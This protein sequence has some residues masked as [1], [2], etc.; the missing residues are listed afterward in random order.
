MN[1]RHA[2]LYLY[3]DTPVHAGGSTS[4]GEVDLPIQRESNGLPVIWGQSL[5]GALRAAASDP[6]SHWTKADVAAVFGD[7][8]EDRPGEDL[9]PGGLSV[10]DAR[11]VA[12]PVPTTS[13][14]FAWA[15]C[16]LITSRL[17]R[18]ATLT[19]APIPTVG[20]PGRDPDRAT[21][22]VTA[23]GQW[24]DR[25]GVG[26]HVLRASNEGIGREDVEGFAGYLAD[27]AIPKLPASLRDKMRA[28]VVLVSDDVLVDGTHSFAE[29]VHRVRLERLERTEDGPLVDNKSVDN[30]FVSEY[31]PAETLL[32]SH[33]YAFDDPAHL[34][35]LARLVDGQ[36]IRVGGDVSAGKGVVWCSI[37]P[38]LI[39]EGA[40]DA[41]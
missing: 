24:V 39:A 29:V 32:V 17:E 28:D 23:G 40:T 16:P 30:L 3:T 18:L 41:N 5:K 33:L 25:I 34:T 31:L 22:Y 7:L 11:L 12:F 38:P 4:S 6:R 35:K 2:L 26:D 36:P 27:H 19:G 1:E 8:F 15:T 37:V 14:V 10:G 20:P 13:R 21:G 9:S